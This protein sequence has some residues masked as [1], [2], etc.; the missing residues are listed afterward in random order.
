MKKN[1][2]AAVVLSTLFAANAFAYDADMAARI[3]PVAARMD[4]AELAKGL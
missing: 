2:I 1:S 4:Q 3:E